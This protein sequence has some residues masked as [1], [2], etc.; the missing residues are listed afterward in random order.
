MCFKPLL[1]VVS[2]AGVPV[3]QYDIMQPLWHHTV[4][5]HQVSDSLQHCLEV[6]LLRLTTHDH[7]KR[8]IHI[9]QNKRV[10]IEMKASFPNLST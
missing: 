3:A 8:L 5:V 10:K 4:S 7:V 1:G 6:V 9:L 2:C